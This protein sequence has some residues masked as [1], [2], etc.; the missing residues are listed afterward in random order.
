MDKKFN[1][2][3][4]YAEEKIADMMDVNR[5]HIT[6]LSISRPRREYDVEIRDIKYLVDDDKEEKTATWSTYSDCEFFKLSD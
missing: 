3:L 2:V 6:V 4:K 1:T 5:R